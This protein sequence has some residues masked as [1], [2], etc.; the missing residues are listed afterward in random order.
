MSKQIAARPGA[1]GMVE[2]R[3]ELTS[4][5]ALCDI[6]EPS[7]ARGKAGSHAQ[8]SVVSPETV[9]TGAVHS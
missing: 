2:V 7:R 5:R 4:P 8:A 3:W 9:P 6:G 1:S